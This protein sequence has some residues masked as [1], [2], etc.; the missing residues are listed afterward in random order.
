MAVG[1]ITVL[2]KTMV[3]FRTKPYELLLWLLVVEETRGS[4]NS[5]QDPLSLGI[6]LNYISQH[7]MVLHGIT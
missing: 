6:Q 4:L 1:V 2:F 3:G 7:T 5:L